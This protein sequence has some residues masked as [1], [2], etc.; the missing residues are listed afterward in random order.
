[1]KLHPGRATYEWTVVARLRSR[2]NDWC[3]PVEN[4]F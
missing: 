3:I 4:A 2:A 1:M